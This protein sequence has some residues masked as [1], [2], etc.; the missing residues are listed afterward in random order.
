MRLIAIDDEIYEKLMV[1]ARAL[2]II[3]ITD[4]LQTALGL[5]ELAMK[6]KV[7]SQNE[8][9]DFIKVSPFPLMEGEILDLGE[10]IESEEDNG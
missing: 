6:K 3:D 5:W 10:Y 8:Q 1:P 2:R 4:I 7:Y 9:G